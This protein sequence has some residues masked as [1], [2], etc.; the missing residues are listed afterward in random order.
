MSFLGDVFEGDAIL[1][2]IIFNDRTSGANDQAFE[3]VIRIV[4]HVGG[5]FEPF[6]RFLDD[7]QPGLGNAAY[8][9]DY[10][11]ATQTLAISDFTNRNVHIFEV[12]SISGVGVFDGSGVYDCIDVD[13]LVMEIVDGSTIGQF[14]L[15]GDGIVDLS[16]LD[17]WLAEAGAL[18]LPSGNPYLKGDANLD[19]VVDVS[20][21]SIWNSSKFTNV[22]AWCSGDF[23]ADG[24]V[25]V[26][27][28]AAWNSNKFTASD[29]AN[30]PEPAGLLMAS[31]ALLALFARKR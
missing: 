8:D 28:F 12:G 17:A 31:L 18:Q 19:G 29:V 5:E 16:D 11:L 9:F 27:D 1:I 6:F 23:T 25:D 30:V 22:A 24:V 3:D 20:D 14:D 21:F 7:V 2:E 13:A 4:D 26:S 10:N 15:T